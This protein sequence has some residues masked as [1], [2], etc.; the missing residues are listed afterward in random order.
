MYMCSSAN[1][2]ELSK[3]RQFVQLTASLA[4][5][6]GLTGCL[7]G[8]ELNNET[9]VYVPEAKPLNVIA[10][11][12]IEAKPG[13]SVTLTSRLVGTST[14]ET[15][16]WSQ[17]SG[18]GVQTSDLQTNTLTFDIPSSILSDRLVFQVA[19]VDA[20][21]N[22]VLNADGDALVDTV[23]V[24]V[25]D[26]DSVIVLDVSGSSATLNGALL[27]VPGD[28]AYIAGADNDTHTAD[29]EPGQ[30]VTFTIDDQSGYFTLNV[31][32]VIPS[33][34]GGKQANITVNGV[35]NAMSFDATGQWADYR[36][37]VVNLNDGVNILEV[38]GGWSYYRIDNISLIPAAQ[39]A[40]PLAVAPTLVNANATDE[41]K[42]LMTFLTANYASST[43]SG[44]TEFPRKEG[45]TFPLTEFNKIVSATGDD[46]PAIVAFDYMNYSASFAG[47]DSSGLSEAMIAAKNEKNVIL[48]ALF[49]W[50]APSG[51]SGDGDGSFYTNGTSFD[52]AAA[53]ADTNSAEY[54]ELLADIDTVAAELQKFE[55]AGIPILWRPLHEAQGGWFWWGAQG[56][57]AFKDLWTLMYERMT[58]VH[59]LDNLIWVFT[60]TE[61]LGEDWYPG[62]NYVDIVGFDGYADPRND[63]TAAFARQYTT[64]MERHNGSK[65]V[66]LTETG[67]IPNVALMHEQNAWWSF[68]LTWNS[69]VWN[70]DSIIG[71]QGA[72][73]ASIDANYAF[74]GLINLAD[75]P[76]GVTGIAPG[77]YANFDVST[78][79]F[80][81][82]VSWSP[83]TGL[84]T[85]SDW[86]TSGSRSLSIVKD[87]SAE[88]NPTNVILQTYPA[89]GIDVTDVSSLTLDAQAINAGANTTIK[90]WAK[91]ADGV[92]RDAGATAVGADPLSLTIDVSDL[93][94]LQGF[95]L[96]I[97]GFDITSTAATFYLDNVRLDDKVA[98]DFEP[99]TSGF[100][101]Q[102]NWSP[103]PGLTVTNDWATSGVNSLT[104]IKDLSAID[105]VNNV[106]FQTYPSGGIDVTG[107]SMLKVSAHAVDAGADTTIK[108]WAKD[109]EGV[110]RDAGATVID[111][112]GL[113]LSID[114]SDLDILQGFGLQIQNFDATSTNAKFY[115]DNVRADDTTLFDF[116]NTLGFEFQVNWS[117]ASGLQLSSDWTA[118]GNSALAGVTQLVEGDDNIIIQ[119]YPAGGI[120]LAGVSSVSV[121]AYAS[122][123]GDAVTA[124]LWAKNQDGVWRDGGAVAMTAE[125][126]TLTVDVSDYEGIQGFGVRYQGAVNSATE[127]QYFIDNVVFE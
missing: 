57:Q 86:A 109:A 15:L 23:E 76:G 90:L 64:L 47:S 81:A 119:T 45:D 25:F 3:K 32:Y 92:W 95:G 67:T 123:A 17:V 117:P 71:P 34:Y 74:D 120:P 1:L 49:H 122:N 55:D 66:A 91:D 56:A 112:A 89:G 16:V 37:G 72:D 11:A 43:L 85:S 41:A 108:L 58:T 27:V 10:P 53:L 115:L 100:E 110:W 21:S 70:S 12:D 114:V 125:G 127:S 60:H 65:L 84:S 68:Y 61:G 94:V 121:T 14:S 96:Q 29:I 93:D 79:G 78:R 104:I 63:D 2:T 126:V 97:Q 105:G 106:I 77:V 99:E 73:P 50:R 28:E 51:N 116:E 18:T 103:T 42:E 52:F 83:T 36:V 4:L 54:A 87:L 26:P 80:E 88:T 24:T 33:D 20:S 19:V 22:P 38:G 69:E 7:G 6:A 98:F 102:I 101:S 75:L 31:R 8:E 48:S 118:S 40:E 62:D 44:Q 13:E 82:Q 39:P 113:E 46:A 111:A 124:Q 35:D 9:A 107:V 59:G 5:V 30:S